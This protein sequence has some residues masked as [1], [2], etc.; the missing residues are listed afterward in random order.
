[1]VLS[2]FV[3]S[4]TTPDLSLFPLKDLTDRDRSTGMA[5]RG[6]VESVSQWGEGR[7][8]PGHLREAQLAIP[9]QV[10]HPQLLGTERGAWVIRSDFLSCGTSPAMPFLLERKKDGWSMLVPPLRSPGG[11]GPTWSPSVPGET[12]GTQSL[13][14]SP[15]RREKATEESGPAPK[16]HA[17]RVYP[18]LVLVLRTLSQKQPLLVSASTS[19][20]TCGGIPFASCHR[21]SLPLGLKNQPTKNPSKPERHR[22]G[23]PRPAPP[24][25]EGRACPLTMVWVYSWSLGSSYGRFAF[26]SRS[27]RNPWNTN[28]PSEPPAQTVLPSH[29]QPFTPFVSVSS[30]INP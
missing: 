25:R 7:H 29:T 14:L 21:E 6:L 20:S 26:F 28:G 15:P 19:V 22:L 2:S 27:D 3:L 10:E 18:L 9:I 30:L 8:I 17:F 16:A 13:L 11:Q 24:G 23:G 12:A 1:M 5:C 4:F